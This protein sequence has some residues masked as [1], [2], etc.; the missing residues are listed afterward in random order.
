VSQ[1][2]VGATL[3]EQLRYYRARADEYDDA[4]RRT[5]SYDRGPHVNAG[6]QADM[7]RVSNAFEQVPLG[8]DI[9]E[10]AAGTGFWT[11]RL[12]RRARSLTV[13][14][15]SPEMLA[16]NR[17]RLGAAAADVRYEVADLF[18]WRPERTWDA[19]VF[20]FWLCHVP[21]DRIAEFLGVVAESL[22]PGGVVSFVDKAVAADPGAERAGRT[23]NDGRCF[24]IIDHPRPSQR[25]VH[26]FAAAGLTVEL[27]TIG[28]R[29]C[30]GHGTRV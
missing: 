10:L 30:V 24:T 27:E 21:D 11:E 15:G 26:E 8:G 6:W 7:T 20:G 23:L 13:I 3:Q 29:F 17:Q 16:L 19:C 14:D 12:V 4:Y 25:L 9:V 5:G 22:R 28:S 2:D 1:P 18:E